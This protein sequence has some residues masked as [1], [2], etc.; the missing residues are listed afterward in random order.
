MT[1]RLVRYYFPTL[2]DVF[3]ATIKRYSERIIAYLT[4]A[5]AARADDPLRAVWEYS[6]DEATGAMMTE[7]MALG[8][9]RKF[10]RTEIAAATEGVRKLQL[11]SLV[12]RFGKNARPTG[13][14][15]LPALQL[16]MSGIPKLI[17]LEEGFGVE[18]AHAEVITALER[19]IDSVEPRASATKRR[20]PRRRTASRGD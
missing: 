18:S 5:L 10:I 4:E 1:P 6:W 13:D 19:Y 20:A 14:L 11:K 15:S 8:N 2:D 12:A 9:H 7:Y 17:N 16:L 3:V